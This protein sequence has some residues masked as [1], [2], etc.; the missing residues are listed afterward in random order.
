MPA[1][2]LWDA[3]CHLQD[4]R[5][6]PFLGPALEACRAAGISRWMVNATRQADWPHVTEL[7]STHPGIL[8]SYGLHPWWQKERS[9]EWASDL[10]QILKEHPKAGIGETGL[11]RWMRDHDLGDQSAVLETHLEIAA[12]LE[13]PLS[14]H[15]LKAWPELK[16][17]LQRH[18]LP[19][20]G[21]LLHSYSGPEEMT[22]HWVQSG[23]Y[24]SFSPAFL[25]PRKIDLRH[26]FATLP[27]ERILIETDCPDMSPPRA[28]ALAPLES[29]R[30]D[31]MN[32]PLNLLLCLEALA[33]DRNMPASGLA[34][35]LFANA[36]RLFGASSPC[37]APPSSH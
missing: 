18:R 21:F 11:D 5:L 28:L 36:L 33:S 22:P 1:P 4:P 24:F 7:A 25:H 17:I 12:Q 14:L 16:G 37:A 8:A 32:H 35:I 13:R 20:C 29:S 34:D 6:A 27:L 15:C 9:K 3:H 31:S 30:G 10:F 23:A 19:A 26:H 2:S